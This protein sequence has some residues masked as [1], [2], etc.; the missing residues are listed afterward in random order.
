MEA[1]RRHL[2]LSRMR[3]MGH[4]GGAAIVLGY[5]S[6]HPDRVERA[7]LIAPP[8]LVGEDST[9]RPHAHSILG[10]IVSPGYAL[11]SWKPKL[12]PPRS[13]SRYAVN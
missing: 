8:T 10:S 12:L 5:A 2:G 13:Q 7:V 11:K 4:S 1:L 9:S 6:L 3:L